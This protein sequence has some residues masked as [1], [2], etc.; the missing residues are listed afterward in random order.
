MEDEKVG[1]PGNTTNWLQHDGCATFGVT[2]A[3]MGVQRSE[4]RGH[5]P[6]IRYVRETGN[7]TV[8]LV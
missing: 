4:S 6:A 1:G 7:L 3:L 5:C 2:R 8:K